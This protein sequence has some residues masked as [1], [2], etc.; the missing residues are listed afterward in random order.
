MFLIKRTSLAIFVF[1]LQHLKDCFSLN[2]CLLGA[3]GLEFHQYAFPLQCKIVLPVKCWLCIDSS[4]HFEHSLLFCFL[5]ELAWNQLCKKSS[6]I[7][8]CFAQKN[9]L[10]TW[11]DKQNCWWGEHSCAVDALVPLVQM[12]VMWCMKWESIN[13]IFFT[14]VLLTSLHGLY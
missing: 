14:A 2:S 6:P 1:L 10:F 12:Q 5:T 9:I 4:K 8:Y 11:C 3:S 13:R 7:S